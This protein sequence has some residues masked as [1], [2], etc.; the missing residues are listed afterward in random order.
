M[1]KE[2]SAEDFEGLFEVLVEDELT[3]A[4]ATCGGSINGAGGVVFAPGSY[5]NH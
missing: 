2:I 3:M 1:M 5:F 4:D